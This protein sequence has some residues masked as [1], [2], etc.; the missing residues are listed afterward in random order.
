[1]LRTRDR[2]APLYVSPGHRCDQASA[3]ALILATTRKY[4]LPIPTRLAHE[5]VNEVRRA[6]H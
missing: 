4:R 3:E 5:H 6:G 1:M 2:V